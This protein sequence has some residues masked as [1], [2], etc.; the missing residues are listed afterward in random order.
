MKKLSLIS[1]CR[2][3]SLI[4]IGLY[5]NNLYIYAAEALFLLFIK[6]KDSLLFTIL[7]LLITLTNSYQNDFIKF[8]VVERKIN[9]YYVVDK[10]LYKTKITSEDINI[11]D[12][13]LTDDY[14]YLDNETYL[15]KNI[16]FSSTNYKIIGNLSIRK[17]LYNKILSFDDVS[18][19][20]LNKFLYNITNYDDLSFN[21]GY[22]LAIY[23]LVK[24]IN[25]KN[26]LIGFFIVILYI[27]LFYFDIKFYLL[28][29]DYVLDK[30]KL[31]NKIFYKFILICLINKYLLISYSIE[32]PIFLAIFNK[33]L[34]EKSFKIGL[35]LMQSLLFGSINIISTFIYKYYIRFQIILLILSFIVLFMP[36]L[37]N[38]Y[39]LLINLYSG[40]NNI[41]LYIRGSITLISLIIYLLAIK[42]FKINNQYIKILILVILIISPINNPFYHVTFIDVGQGDSILIKSELNRSNVL[43]DTGSSFNYYKL[44]QILYKEGIYSIDYLIITHNDSDH[45]GNIESLKL[46]FK[47]KNIIDRN[48]DID[49]REIK[50][51]NLYT[52][53]YDNDNDNSL[54]YYMN[55]NDIGFLFT[56]DISSDCERKLVNKYP[57]LDVDILKVSHHGSK[58]GTS[59]YLVSNYLPSIACI[60]TSGQYGHPHIQ[61]IS[62]L[63]DY[64]VKIYSTKQNKNIRI[65]FTKLA[66]ILKTDNLEFAIIK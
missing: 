23:Y 40:F 6:Y 8:G 22:G 51:Y 44:K 57:N 27:L 37:L 24:T 4:C 59:E 26:K 66:N 36:S 3:I 28:L 14:E 33:F 17:C 47:V 34:D 32:I 20:S 46:D 21:L 63:N 58:T 11:G 54:V 18:R 35:V 55:I 45:N 60:S 7:I 13:L 25:K 50:L 2:L 10:I 39:L 1:A 42:S 30:Y 16:K 38:I 19:N 52:K 9:N 64:L 12:I 31:N 62:T 61:T 65:Y 56:G 41:G 15:K 5:F 49:S 29:F 43:I 53:N 48:I